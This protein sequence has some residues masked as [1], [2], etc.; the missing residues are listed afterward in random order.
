MINN[1]KAEVEKRTGLPANVVD[2]VI[3]ALGQIVSE[4]YPQYA[5]MIGPILGIPT[6]T[7]SASGA[8]SGG[9]Q[10]QGMS[11]LGELES[12]GGSIFGGQGQSNQ[13]GDTAPKS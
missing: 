11:A 12:L 13:G 8:T 3:S 1:I 7:S 2:Q 4:R 10:P 5:S 6:G 9:S